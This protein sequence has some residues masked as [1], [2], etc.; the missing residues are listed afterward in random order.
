MIQEKFDEKA[1]NIHP[2]DWSDESGLERCPCTERSFAALKS[3]GRS[4]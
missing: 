4:A 1:A 3:Q 2:A